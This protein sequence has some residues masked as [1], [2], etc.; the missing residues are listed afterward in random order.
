MP[1]DFGLLE[2]HREIVAIE[3]LSH[4]E[5]ALADHL[6]ARLRDFG[7]AVERIEDNVFAKAGRGPRLLYNTHFDTVPASDAWTRD[8][9]EVTV[10]DGRVYGLGSN[11]A[12]ASVA[13][14]VGALI[15]A[16]KQGGPCELGVLLVPEEETGGRGAEVAWPALRARGWTPEAVVVG[17]PTGLD[18]AIA[19]KGLL[20]CELVTRGDGGHSANAAALGARNAIRELA[21]DLVALESADLG[22]DHP[23]LGSTTCEPTMVR[24]GEAR[25]KVAEEAVCLL[26]LR[27]V[28][29]REPAQLVAALQKQV[30]SEIRVVSER[31]R[32][33]ECSP[34][35]T[36]VHAARTAHPDAKL[37]GSRTISDWVYFRDIPGIKCGPGR[38]E[39]SH[40][41][42]EFVLE[43]EIVEGRRFYERLCEAFASE[44]R[45]RLIAGH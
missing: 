45:G 4:R 18:I 39:R 24:G 12:K 23:L 26:D 14:M 29:G 44:S 30:Q 10:E 38:T 17:E 3:S 41:P 2:F 16:A 19:Q 20:I 40:Q 43:E 9:H 36:V 37:Y 28:P 33:I 5:S 15:T 21:R 35:E 7:L 22:G 42:D 13:A 6:E 34:N 32:S 31:L 1:R 8:P 11:D 25:N 27:T